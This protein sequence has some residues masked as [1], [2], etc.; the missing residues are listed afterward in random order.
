MAV[1]AATTGTASISFQTTS[2]MIPSNAVMGWIGEDGAGGSVGSYKLESYKAVG[3]TSNNPDLPLRN[4]SI[5][6]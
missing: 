3:V 4:E 2:R 1:E 5:E 6:R